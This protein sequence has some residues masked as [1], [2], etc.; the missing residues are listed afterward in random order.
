MALKFILEEY[1]SWNFSISNPKPCTKWCSCFQDTVAWF[2]FS[3]LLCT[4]MYIVHLCIWIGCWNWFS[5]PV[6]RIFK[7]WQNFQVLKHTFPKIWNI[8]L[9]FEVTVEIFGWVE[10]VTFTFHELKLS[11]RVGY[12]FV[13]KINSAPIKANC[14]F[15]I[16]YHW[17]SSCKPCDHLLFVCQTFTRKTLPKA[18]RTR[19]LSSSYQSN[20]LRSYHMLSSLRRKRH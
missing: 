19:G 9:S 18:Q 2:I 3:L 1:Q 20:F 6:L 16:V 17:P 11:I 8:D 7:L 14:L 4:Y 5:F 15:R 10:N 12:K 13:N